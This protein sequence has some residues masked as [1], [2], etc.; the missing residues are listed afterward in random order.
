MIQR[1]ELNLPLTKLLKNSISIH[2]HSLSY[3]H[4]ILSYTALHIFILADSMLIASNYYSQKHRS[5]C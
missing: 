1:Q 4:M 2:H 5:D 3:D